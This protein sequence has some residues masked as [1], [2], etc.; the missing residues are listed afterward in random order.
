M[1]LLCH[2]SFF[3]FPGMWLNC[4][5]VTCHQSHWEFQLQKPDIN[6][7]VGPSAALHTMNT[8]SQEPT[9]AAVSYTLT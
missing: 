1:G 9:V 7:H 6:R 2:S 5:S 4:G 3:P 8:L